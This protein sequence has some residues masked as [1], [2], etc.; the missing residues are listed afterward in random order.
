MWSGSIKVSEELDTFVFRVYDQAARKE[1][2][3]SDVMN[4]T[5]S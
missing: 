2:T 3:A 1:E 4:L 5:V